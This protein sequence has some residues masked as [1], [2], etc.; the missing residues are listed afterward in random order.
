MDM[1]PCERQFL[2]VLHELQHKLQFIKNQEFRDVQSTSDVAQIADQL[3]LRV[4]F[5]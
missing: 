3:K 4:R 5:L 2:E 1:D